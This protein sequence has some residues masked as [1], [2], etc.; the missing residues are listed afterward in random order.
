MCDQ[1]LEAALV[2]RMVEILHHSDEKPDIGE[3]DMW[4]EAAFPA[5][6]RVQELESALRET[7]MKFKQLSATEWEA[8]CGEHDV[9]VRLEGGA[10]IVDV[11]DSRKPKAD[12]A[13]LTSEQFDTWG[14]VETFCRGLG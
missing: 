14:E 2:Q 10:Y 4:P 3:F 5:Q 1:A 8:S 6:K 12:T 11:F 13:Y 9:S 7:K